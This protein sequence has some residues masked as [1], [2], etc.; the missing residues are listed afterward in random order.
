[1]RR[2]RRKNGAEMAQVPG[3]E[4]RLA[5]LRHSPLPSAG[6]E[7][8]QEWRSMPPRGGNGAENGARMAQPKRRLSRAARLS[9]RVLGIGE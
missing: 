6:G 7:W 1:M 8:R 2:E 3:A 4:G 5:P 9:L